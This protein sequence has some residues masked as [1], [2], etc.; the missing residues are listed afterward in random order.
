MHG[1]LAYPLAERARSAVLKAREAG[2]L[3]QALH[4]EEV[5]EYYPQRVVG[6]VGQEAGCGVDVSAQ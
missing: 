6:G 4:A 1:A 2:V 3:T 5:D